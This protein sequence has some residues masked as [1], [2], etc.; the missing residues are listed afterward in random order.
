MNTIFRLSQNNRRISA[1]FDIG[2]EDNF[3]SQRLTIKIN[4]FSERVNRSEIT[5]DEYKIYIY[6]SY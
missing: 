1:L 2:A 4:L 5:I 6:D 3:I